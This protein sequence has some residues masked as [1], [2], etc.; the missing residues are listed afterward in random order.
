MQPNNHSWMSSGVKTHR[1]S[2]LTSL[3]YLFYNDGWHN[4]VD[5]QWFK[6]TSYVFQSCVTLASESWLPMPQL[7]LNQCSSITQLCHRHS[8]YAIHMH[9][10]CHTHVIHVPYA[11]YACH[12]HAIHMTYTCH[13]HVI[14]MS[15]TCHTHDKH[16]PYTC[17]THVIHMTYTCHTH[18]IRMPYTYDIHMPYACHTHAI[19][20]PDSSIHHT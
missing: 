1:Y 14:H 20:M 6:R 10:T 8:M 3:F 11:N 2:K 15:Y 18:A 5:R 13:T 16:M 4:E 12:T 7:C 17:H 19:H 9:Y